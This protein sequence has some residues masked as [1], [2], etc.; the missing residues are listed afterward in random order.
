VFPRIMQVCYIREYRLELTFADGVRAEMDFRKKVVGRG[1][2]FKP[3]ED[4]E[5]FRQV[6]VDSEGGTLTWPNAVDL[7]PDVLYSEATGTPIP[8]VEAA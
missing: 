5:F 8:M 2:V 6:R 4:L 7:D 3:L 1:G